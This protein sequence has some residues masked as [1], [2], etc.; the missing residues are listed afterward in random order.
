MI[1]SCKFQHDFEISIGEKFSTISLGRNVLLMMKNNA[2]EKTERSNAIYITSHRRRII[3]D[4]NTF[5]GKE[6][7][8][9]SDI[10][11]KNFN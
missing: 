4:N 5:D 3:S 6:I 1:D 7:W 2:F 8:D 10:E 11:F 9:R